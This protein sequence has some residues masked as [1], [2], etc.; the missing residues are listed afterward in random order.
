MKIEDVYVV[1]ITQCK[2]ISSHS[3][4]IDTFY[5]EERAIKYAAQHMMHCR[6]T[7]GIYPYEAFVLKTKKITLEDKDIK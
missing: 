1:N 7:C 2:C 4:L 3:L 5:T 6:K